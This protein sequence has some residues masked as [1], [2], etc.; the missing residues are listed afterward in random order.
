MHL[1]GTLDPVPQRNQPETQGDG[2]KQLSNSNDNI[3]TVYYYYSLTGASM[4]GIEGGEGSTS[5]Q[6][7][8]GE[9]SPIVWD[10][11]FDDPSADVVLIANADIHFRAHNWFL[12][13]NR[14]IL[15]RPPF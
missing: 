2:Y 11:H 15:C 14:W 5:S 6:H 7:V 4:D 13:R 9:S 1:M 12:K 10:K 8:D 3:L